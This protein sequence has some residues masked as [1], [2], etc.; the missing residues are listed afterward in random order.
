MLHVLAWAQALPGS[1]EPLPTSHSVFLEYLEVLF[2]LAGVLILAYALLR[3]G[4]P[5][6]L[7][8]AG[9]SDGP[10]RIVARQ[11]LEPRKTLYLVS[12][13]SQLFL[14]GTAES[15]VQ[16]LTAIDPENAATLLEAASREPVRTKDFRQVMSWFQ[17]AGKADC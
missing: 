10:I 17:K 5:R 8:M 13:G 1:A 16:C 12:V 4:L 6:M 9:A 2:V 7:G 15:Q 14:L 11:G 3:L